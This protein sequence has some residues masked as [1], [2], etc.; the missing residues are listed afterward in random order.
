MLVNV[1]GIPGILLAVYLGR[2]YFA[3]FVTV[4]C[5]LALGEF[6]RLS[7]RR[8]ASPRTWL[9]WAG[10]LAIAVFYY[11][12]MESTIG[13]V[14]WQQTLMV[15]IL[16]AAILELFSGTENAMVNIAV[17]IAGIIYVPLLLGALIVVRQIDLIDYGFS[18]RLTMSL[19]IAVW[20]CDSA[21][22][23]FGR[24]WGKKKILE[25]VSPNKTVVGSTFGLITAVLVYV[26]MAESG[27]LSL[28]RN[29]HSFNTL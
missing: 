10:C 1:L 27:F 4:I 12:G 3:I 28:S 13:P 2:F 17:T 25:R 14:N 9:G 26:V 16:L 5:L 29:S 11:R 23:A 18:M 22:Y 15:L 20:L 24:K 8:G 19:F 7:A 6:Y 21:A